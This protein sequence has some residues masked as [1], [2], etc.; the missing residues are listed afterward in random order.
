MRDVG[1]DPNP[2]NSGRTVSIIRIAETYWIGSHPN[3]TS[4]MSVAAPSKTSSAPMTA[5]SSSTARMLPYN[6]SGSA[7]LLG[8][9]KKKNDISEDSF[10]GHAEVVP[11]NAT[12]V[13]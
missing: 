10:K 3:N 6:F 7:S 9:L 12:K 2:S 11:Q 8:L 1:N 5:S 4:S 13:S